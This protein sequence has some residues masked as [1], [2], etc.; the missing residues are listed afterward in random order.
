MLEIVCTVREN[1]NV[2]TKDRRTKMGTYTFLMM[3]TVRGTACDDIF[4]IH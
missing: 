2:T 1:L 3:S 4:V